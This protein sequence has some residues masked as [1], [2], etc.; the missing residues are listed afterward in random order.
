MQEYLDITNWFCRFK[1]KKTQ[2]CVGREEGVDLGRVGEWVNMIKTCKKFKSPRIN[3]V[4]L[5]GKCF[6]QR[7]E[8]KFPKLLERMLIE[9]QKTYRR[10]NGHK[11]NSPCYI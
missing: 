11:I 4:F 2:S 8:G 3:K 10:Q 7:H 9:E 6:E 5:N 1:R